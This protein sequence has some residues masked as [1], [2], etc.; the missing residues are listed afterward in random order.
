M[1]L[2]LVYS[3]CFTDINECLSSPCQH[4]TCIDKVDSYSCNCSPGYIGRDCDTGIETLKQIKISYVFLVSLAS[5][6]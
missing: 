1:N 4:G 6:Q 5:D 3:I 2:T